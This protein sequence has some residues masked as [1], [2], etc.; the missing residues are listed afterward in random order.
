MCLTIPRVSLRSRYRGGDYYGAPAGA[1]PAR[2]YPPSRS[3]YPRD[4]PGQRPLPAAADFYPA[5]LG[6]G[7]RGAAPGGGRGRFGQQA[8]PPRPLM[9]GYEGAPAGWQEGYSRSVGRRLCV[10]ALA[11]TTW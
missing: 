9:G 11:S 1:P 8:P 2:D 4:F 5:P 3:D 6:G 10:A 7:D